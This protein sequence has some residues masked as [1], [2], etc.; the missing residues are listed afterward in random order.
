MKLKD[1]REY[2]KEHDDNKISHDEMNE[3]E[4]KKSFTLVCKKCGSMDVDF[5]GE[6]GKDYGGQTGYSSEENG[7]KCN[8]CGNAITWWQ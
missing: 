6:A 2:V 1:F 7:F 4:F 3:G 5:F 8:K